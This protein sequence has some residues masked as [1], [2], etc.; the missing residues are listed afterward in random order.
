MNINFGIGVDMESIDRFKKGGD[1]DAPFLQKTFTRTELDY[2]FSCRLPAQ[3]LAVRFAAKEA[4]IKALGSLRRANLGYKDIEITNDGNGAPAARILKAGF[5]DLEMKVSL[6]H[7]KSEA[8]AFV[9]VSL[10]K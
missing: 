6:S 3:H 5:D 2:C 10:M 9:L 7:S 4:V 8:I 1:D